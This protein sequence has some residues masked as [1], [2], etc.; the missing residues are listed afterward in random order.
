MNARKL[1]IQY[2]ERGVKWKIEKGLKNKGD[3]KKRGVEKIRE[4]RK[5]KEEK[6]MNGAQTVHLF[7]YTYVLYI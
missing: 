6:D 3:K 2:K 4:A 5:G 1:K 7:N